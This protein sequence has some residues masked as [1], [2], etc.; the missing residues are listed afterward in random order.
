MSNLPGACWDFSSSKVKHFA[1]ISLCGPFSINF[2]E[3]EDLFI[4][5]KFS[6]NMFLSILWTK[7]FEFFFSPKIITLSVKSLFFLLH[8][9]GVSQVFLHH[10]R[11]NFLQSQGY[12]V[13]SNKIFNSAFFPFILAN[14]YLTC[15]DLDLFIV[16]CSY[17]IENVALH[18]KNNKK[19]REYH[20]WLYSNVY[21]NLDKV[22]HFPESKI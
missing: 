17:F 12:F 7:H 3:I 22:N 15:L 21:E 16:L 19:I 4:L 13:F 8:L 1:R 14:F 2:P 6:S 20:I 18:L 9:G 5:E 11:F 10:H